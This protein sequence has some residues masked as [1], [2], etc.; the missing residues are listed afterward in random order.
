VVDKPEI[1]PT[2]DQRQ[3]KPEPEKK[4]SRRA[5]PNRRPSPSRSRPSPRT[6]AEARSDRR[7]AEERHTSREEAGKEG[8]DA[9]AAEEAGAAKPQ[10]KFDA[11]A[12]RRC[13]TSATPTPRCDGSTLSNTPS[14]G[15]A[16]GRAP[17]AVAERARR[18]ARALRQCWNV[19]VGL[20]ERARPGRDVG[21][22]STR[23]ARCAEP[24]LMNQRSH[25]AFQRHPKARCARFA[26][27][28]PTASFPWPIRGWKDV[29]ID[30]D[31]RDMF[32]G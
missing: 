9:D 4:P 25:P 22:S 7:G 2:A 1:V 15:T 27:A 8:R 29:I 23:T 24:P 19:P 10:P 6:G 28:R 18:A 3:P 12:S 26:A 11:S 20:A 21:S 17:S 32:R 13:S 14:L 30:F 16:T 5:E 31:P